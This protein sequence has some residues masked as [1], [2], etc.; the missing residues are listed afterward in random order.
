LKTSPACGHSKRTEKLD[1]GFYTASITHRHAY[2]A[3]TRLIHICTLLYTNY[4]TINVETSQK[5]E[6]SCIGMSVK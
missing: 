5:H 1:R 3:H 4:T 6:N 2:N